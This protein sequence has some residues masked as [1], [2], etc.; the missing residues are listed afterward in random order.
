MTNGTLTTTPSTTAE[1]K[2]TSTSITSATS[3]AASTAASKTALSG[4]QVGGILGGLVGAALILAG[5]ALLLYFS[6][7]RRDHLLET[8][9]TGHLG[10]DNPADE[11]EKDVPMLGGSMRQEMDAQG[12]SALH[13]ME[14]V[15]DRASCLGDGIEKGMGR[16]GISELEGERRVVAEL[17]GG[18]DGRDSGRK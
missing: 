16:E 1:S 11:G 9:D 7:R 5:I 17:D 6:R 4:S 10:P 15:G 2:P 14:G 13:E 12:G 3:T 18:F 8:S